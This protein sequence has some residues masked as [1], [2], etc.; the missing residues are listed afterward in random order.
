MTRDFLDEL[1]AAVDG[2]CSCGC[3]A[4]ITDASARAYWHGGRAVTL[5]DVVVQIIEKVRAATVAAVRALR[6]VVERLAAAARRIAAALDLDDGGMFSE[7][8]VP[9]PRPKPRIDPGSGLSSAPLGRPA[10]R[11][12]RT[13]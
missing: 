5:P 11:P 12:A 3:N 13:Y 4:A 7:R 6:S 8:L 10:F 2:R 1:D 9:L